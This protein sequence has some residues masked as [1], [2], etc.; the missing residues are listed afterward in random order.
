MPYED[1]D[2]NTSDHGFGDLFGSDDE[3][4]DID[5]GRSQ[6]SEEQQTTS[7]A[8]T[9]KSS[10]VLSSTAAK[11]N[12]FDKLFGSSDE[13]SE[14]KIEKKQTLKQRSSQFES[15]EDEQ[16][17]LDKQSLNEYE[18]DNEGYRDNDYRSSYKEKRVEVSVELPQLSLPYSDDNKYYLVKLPHYL[19]I[20]NNPFVAEEF[21]V[22]TGEGLSEAQ[23]QESIREQVESTI[24]WRRVK[25]DG[26]ETMQSNAHF[27]EWEDGRMSLMLGDECFDISSKPVGSHEH[28]YLLAHQSS[29]GA[30]ES[31]T[32]LTDYM[33]FRPSGLMSDTHRYLTAQI[34][35]KQI[36]K[37]KTK[38]FFT[39]KDPERMKHE[40]EAQENERLKAQRKLEQ[41]RR[42]AD[43]RYND[44]GTRRH[45]DFGDFDTVDYSSN[46]SS[47]HLAQDR[48]EDD[49]VVDDD[50][51]DEEEE[52]LRENRLSQ[53]KRT[54]MDRYKRSNYSDE[55]E[56]E[57][58]DYGS[59]EEE[60]D[61]EEI[62]VRRHKRNRI[63]SDEDE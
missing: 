62:V 30:L 15:S 23:E 43:L 35:D 41:Q 39:E 42:K 52:R 54:G 61:D 20:E 22:Q 14:E 27:V 47:S 50:E 24:R 36:K 45:N 6:F 8:N 32:E 4:S 38:I 63:L 19:D 49:F 26:I 46:Y 48:Y 34:A 1:D 10:P 60:D 53:V 18:D 17:N 3:A 55:D 12:D 51:Y 56:E 58:Y 7:A 9:L 2:K 16:D 37:N 33:A 44:V 28:I 31:Q 11:T 59:E 57:E 21:K 40:L 25:E 5:D 13:E 29:A